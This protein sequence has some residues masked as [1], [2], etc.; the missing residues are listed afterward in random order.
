MKAQARYQQNEKYDGRKEKDGFV[1]STETPKS[2]YFCV[3]VKIGEGKVQIRDTK[4]LND[5]TLTFTNDEWNAFI[6]GIKQGEFDLV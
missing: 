2:P 3:A 5:M 4:D 6:S 1:T